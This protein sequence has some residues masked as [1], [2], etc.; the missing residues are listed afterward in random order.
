MQWRKKVMQFEKTG[1]CRSF[2]H[3][4]PGSPLYR[5]WNI[6]QGTFRTGRNRQHGSLFGLNA[7]TGS[8][9]CPGYPESHYLGAGG[10]KDNLYYI[11]GTRGT[12]DD[13]VFPCLPDTF[14]LGS[15]FLQA[16]ARCK[17]IAIVAIL[18]FMRFNIPYANTIGMCSLLVAAIL[19]LLG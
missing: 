11:P 14:S 3:W 13:S 12:A 5:L 17:Y 4:D 8:F 7:G 18:S 6:W 16:A 19:F 1:P 15:S 10:G 2:C 9:Q